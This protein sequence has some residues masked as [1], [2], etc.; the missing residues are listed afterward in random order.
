MRRKI[1][2][3][4]IISS[5]MLG[6]CGVKGQLKT[7]PPLW[8]DKAKQEYEEKYGKKDDSSQKQTQDQDQ[9]NPDN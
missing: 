8:G 2:A 9:D 7:P 5:F 1:L 3:A 4:A 6:A